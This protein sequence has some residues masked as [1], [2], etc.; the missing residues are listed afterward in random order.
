MNDTT[1][2]LRLIDRD[3]NFSLEAAVQGDKVVFVMTNGDMHNH[4]WMM[5]A[6]LGAARDQLAA[7]LANLP[8]AP[9]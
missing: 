4:R 9:R 5:R 3:R 7:F 2:R 1:G 6:D 8:G